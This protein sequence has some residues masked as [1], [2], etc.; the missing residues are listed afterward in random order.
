VANFGVGGYGTDQAFLRHRNRVND[1]APIVILGIF[2]DNVQRN[3]NRFRELLAGSPAF[4]F[5]PRFK[6]DPRGELVLLPL[7][8]PDTSQARAFIES[9][10]QFLADEYFLPGSSAGPVRPRFPFTLSLI[11]LLLHPDVRAVLTGHP[12]WERYY[13]PG[14]DSG[15][16][17]T[18]VGIVRAFRD[19][20]GRRGQRLMIVMFLSPKTMSRLEGA[21]ARP[22]QP[23][24]DRI[25]AEGIP[26]V[27]LS[28][29]IL[30]RLS[31][32]SPCEIATQPRACRGHLNPEANAWVAEIVAAA[33]SR[34]GGVTGRGGR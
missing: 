21:S 11:H 30:L 28:D 17:E 29:G 6:L 15:A 10:E 18:T 31:G 7:S 24:I 25:G 22:Y 33:L 34:E 14:H 26:I 5:K 8:L 32:R 13:R 2:E 23:L 27:D 3:V 20:A 19:E 16:L 4:S 9:P 1:S 12:Y